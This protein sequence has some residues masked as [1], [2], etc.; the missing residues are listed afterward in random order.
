[1]HST[2]N[3]LIRASAGTGKTYQL[4]NRY[5]RL[6]HRSCPPERILATTFTRKAAGEILE[7][8]VLRL[9]EAAEG[10]DAEKYRHQLAL[11]IGEP[12]LSTEQV[13]QMLG[14]LLRRLHRI[15]VATLDSF[16][17]QI[18]HSFSLDLGLPP[19]WQIIDKLQDD[20]LRQAAVSQMLDDE[21][22]RRR[23]LLRL[24]TQG[25]AVRRL[26]QLMLDTV[27]DVYHMYREADD[28]AW[29]CLQPRSEPMSPAEVMQLI[30]CLQQA[31]LPQNKTFL[32]GHQ[33]ALAAALG[34]DWIGFVSQT[35]VQ[36]VVDDEEK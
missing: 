19:G 32:G 31:E 4:S 14:Q 35:I 30:D 28:K 7:R 17:G 20:A 15:R 2:R 13:Q 16:F 22:Q 9:A 36:K 33:K 18:A 26:S 3:L 24:L 27:S 8:I 6:I 34:G 25:D 23:V 29:E 11:A 10:N 21:P 12:S 5:L 1:M